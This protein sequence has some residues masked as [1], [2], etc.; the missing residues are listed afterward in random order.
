[1]IKKKIA[2]Y[3][4]LHLLICFQG[5]TYFTAHYKTVTHSTAQS[6]DHRKDVRNKDETKESSFRWE[7]I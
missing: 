3:N 1:M 4:F 6:E 5:K 7:I 2:E